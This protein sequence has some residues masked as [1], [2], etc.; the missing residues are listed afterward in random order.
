VVPKGGL[1]IQ[2]LNN[3]DT[4]PVLV[5]ERLLSKPMHKSLKVNASSQNPEFQ[6]L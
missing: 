1:A 3:L 4:D 5:V 6:P 2:D